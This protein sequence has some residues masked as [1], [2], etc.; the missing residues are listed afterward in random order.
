ML[1]PC[2]RCRRHVLVEASQCPF[3]ALQ[4]APVSQSP[5]VVLG[6]AILIA[7]CGHASPAPQ[8]PAASVVLPVATAAPAQSAQ[9]RDAAPQEDSPAPSASAAPVAS[10]APTPP[11]APD[12]P[13]TTV[14]RSNPGRA[15][16]YGPPPRNAP[17]YGPPPSDA[18][19]Y[20]PP[21]SDQSRDRDSIR[22]VMESAKGRFR[23]CWTSGAQG[24]SG[25]VI[26]RVTIAKDGKVAKAE[27]SGSTL[28]AQVDQCLTAMAKTLRFGPASTEMKVSYP[29]V[30][31]P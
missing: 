12:P 23:S 20:G 16:V 28:P 15:A 13:A 5:V 6:S 1:I 22:S 29:L 11:D 18:P 7:G 8:E 10:S 24:Q 9:A 25:R 4:V 14:P 27:T 31:V 26:L 17:V 3:C 21:P 2:P 19:M 30:F